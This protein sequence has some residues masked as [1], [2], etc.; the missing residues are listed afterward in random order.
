[1]NSSSTLEADCSKNDLLCFG[2]SLWNLICNGNGFGSVCHMSSISSYL[3]MK[4]RVF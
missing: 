4:M 3:R 2:P 1:M